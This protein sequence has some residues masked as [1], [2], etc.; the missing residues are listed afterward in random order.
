MKMPAVAFALAICGLAPAPAGALQDDR[1]TQLSD[2]QT[3]TQWAHAEWK[4]PVRPYPDG[5]APTKAR[6]RFDSEDGLQEVYTALRSFRH[7]DG[8][9]WIEIRLPRRPNGQ[10]G[11]VRRDA[12][13]SFHVVRTLL[14]IDR[15]KLRAT[16]YRDGE[17]VWSARVGVGAARTPTPAGRF[18]IRGRLR[19]PRGG[20][21]GDIAFPTSAYSV[22]S[23]WPGG[24]VVGIHGTNQPELIPGRP[25]HGCIRIEN[26]AIRRLAELLPNG[27]PVRII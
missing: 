27:S 3:F 7:P 21:Y 15:A 17:Q 2:E 5:S 26:A 25:S 16:L 9:K 4:A 12:L 1:V 10:T 24:G 8:S 22:L 20:L 23:D 13:R 11:W 19:P 18:Y 6:L 14:L